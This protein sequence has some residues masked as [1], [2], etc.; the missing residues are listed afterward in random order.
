MNTSQ[1]LTESI[2]LTY[3]QE[4]QP[5]PSKP[6]AMSGHTLG[7]HTCSHSLPSSIDLGSVEEINSTLIGNGHEPFSNLQEGAK[8]G[9]ECLASP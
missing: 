2:L 3:A 7:F 9:Q 1:G 5:L 8:V 6:A 4:E